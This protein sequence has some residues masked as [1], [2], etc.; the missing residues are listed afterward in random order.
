MD[1]RQFQKEV[2]IWSRRN[3]GVHK[4]D[5]PF[6]GIVEEVGELA[7]AIL[8]ARQGIRKGALSPEEARK[9]IKDAV[10]D[11]FIYTAD[12]CASS[13][14]DLDETVKEVW[15]EVKQRDWVKYPFDGV[16]R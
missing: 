16:T 5:D 15:D 7:H 2:H 8:K 14:I 12:Y 1:L 4:P 3:F 10:G 13:N 9:Q 6:L 11:L